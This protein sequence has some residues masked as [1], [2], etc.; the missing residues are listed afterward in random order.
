[1]PHPFASSKNIFGYVQNNFKSNILPC[2]F[3]Y[4]N[5]VEKCL[6]TF[7]KYWNHSKQFE[8]SQ[9]IFQLAD[10]LDISRQ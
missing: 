5:M 10:G 3:D 8:C 7:K 2:K 6:T 9:N 4:L 1:M